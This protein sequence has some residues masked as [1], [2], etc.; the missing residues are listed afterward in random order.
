MVL[1]A[2]L[3]VGRLAA[4]CPAKNFV[5]IVEQTSSGGGVAEG[6]EDARTRELYLHD[7]KAMF[8]RLFSLR[9]KIESELGMKLE[10]LGQPD[11]KVSR[12]IVFHPNDFR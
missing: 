1:V 8:G 11:R 10:W 6:D 4:E 9:E 12:S 3:L 7:D 2:L 5:V